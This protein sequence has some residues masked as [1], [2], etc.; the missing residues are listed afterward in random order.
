MEIR[1]SC[2]CGAIQWKVPEPTEMHECNCS[3]C[4]RLGAIWAAYSVDQFELVTMPERLGGYQFGTFK[5]QHYHCPNCGM[6][7]HGWSPGWSDDGKPD[8]DN[9]QIGVNMRMAPEF[10]R[11]AYTIEQMDGK[12]Y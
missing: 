11:S 3:Y 10:D 4:A 9:P 1:G 8:F 5:G 6:A 12:K 7:T 2:H